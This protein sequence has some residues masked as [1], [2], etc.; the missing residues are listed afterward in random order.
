MENGIIKRTMVVWAIILPVIL[1]SHVFGQNLTGNVKDGYGSYGTMGQDPDQLIEYG[2]GMMRYGF[3]EK[4]ML[5]GSSK[6]PGYNRELRDGT[7][8]KL[9][10][11]QEAFIQATEELRQTIYEK[12]LYLKAE[13]V[14]KEPNAEKALNLQDDIS[15]A[16]GKFKQK[17]IEHL[18]RMKRIN[19]EAERQ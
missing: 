6:Y 10:N 18:L 12:E 16:E 13:L 8:K 11:E 2:Q 9:N 17:M 14:K 5:G 4:G 1:A 7:V 15:G 3:H 19:R